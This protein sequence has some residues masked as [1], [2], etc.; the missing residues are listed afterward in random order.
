ME[1]N[2]KELPVIFWIG[3]IALL[4][5]AAI[6]IFALLGKV[7]PDGWEENTS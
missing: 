5:A 1:E 3:M 4:T 6:G 7:A 2:K